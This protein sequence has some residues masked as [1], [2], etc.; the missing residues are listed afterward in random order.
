MRL[1]WRLQ[2]DPCSGLDR[3]QYKDKR[4]KQWLNCL[5]GKGAQQ[6]QEEKERGKERGDASTRRNF[7]MQPEKLIEFYAQQKSK[8][9]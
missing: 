5:D 2:R 1:S 3:G 9:T 8:S 6:Q 4:G 7:W